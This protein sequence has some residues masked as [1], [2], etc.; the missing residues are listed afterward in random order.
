M[1]RDIVKYFM[2]LA[3]ID[4]ESKDERRI[5]D[6]LIEDLKLMGADVYEDKTHEK[7]AG[8]AGN[9]LATFKGKLDKAPIL[10]CAHIDTV[11][12]GIGVKPTL[13]DDRIVSDGT[14]VLGAD[15]KSGVAQIICG[16]SE[17]LESGAVHAPIEVLFTVSEEIGL[18]GAKY[19]DKTRLK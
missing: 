19:F 14:T 7:T 16:I 6:R 3:A 5:A 17:L 13:L 18:L 2:E 8:N 4:S 12:P 15:D 9:I 1:K 11:K 10:F